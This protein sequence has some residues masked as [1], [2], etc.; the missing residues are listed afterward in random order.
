MNK[1]TTP[2]PR[3]PAAAKLATTVAVGS[4]AQGT[5][6]GRCM[7][8]MGSRSQGRCAQTRGQEWEGQGT[9]S[10]SNNSGSGITSTGQMC[11]NQGLQR[12]TEDVFTAVVAAELGAA[13]T[14]PQHLHHSLH[15][16]LP[17]P[18]YL[19]IQFLLSKY[20]WHKRQ[21]PSHSI[22]SLLSIIY[23]SNSNYSSNF[24]NFNN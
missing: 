10:C 18:F 21:Q 6:E 17:N 23:N 13:T 1:G 11:T 8:G 12:G 9:C 3:A 16:P 22:F 14:V 5:N 15:P 2:L 7:A 24:D 20:K 19:L 4:G